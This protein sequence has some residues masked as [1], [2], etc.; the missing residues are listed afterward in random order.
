MG[1]EKKR[2]FLIDTDAGVD[3]AQAILMALSQPD[4]EV[5]A[6]TATHGNATARQVTKNV[7]RLLKV[8]NRLD[9]SS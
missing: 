6:I 1:S 3:D 8:A 2:Y 4:I 9:V 5:K 7:L